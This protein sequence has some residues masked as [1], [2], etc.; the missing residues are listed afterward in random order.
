MICTIIFDVIDS[1]NIENLK[2]M[3]VEEINQALIDASLE[4]QPQIDPKSPL[5]VTS[6]MKWYDEDSSIWSDIETNFEDEGVIY[7]DGYKAN[8]EEGKVIAKINKESGEVV[9]IDQR[10]KTDT[11]AQNMIKVVLNELS[12]L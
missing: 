11:Y 1:V 8:D 12:G 6:I 7:V 10:A 9:Y 4:C 5:V 3:I 2:N